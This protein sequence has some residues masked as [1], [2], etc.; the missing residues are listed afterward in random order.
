M[1]TCKVNLLICGWICW[2]V[3]WVLD[4]CVQY[5]NVLFDCATCRL[6]LGVWFFFRVEEVPS[7]I[8]GADL[9]LHPRTHVRTHFHPKVLNQS[10]RKHWMELTANNLNNNKTPHVVTRTTYFI[11]RPIGEITQCICTYNHYILTSYYILQLHRQ[12]IVS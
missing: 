3:C 2:Y 10:S 4:A 7:S 11:T 9:F 5:Y 6:G 8:L 1:C 12:H